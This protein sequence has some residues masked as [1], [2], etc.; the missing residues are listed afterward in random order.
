[1]TKCPDFSAGEKWE[2]ETEADPN[3]PDSCYGCQYLYRVPYECWNCT[4]PDNHYI[5][6][7]PHRQVTDK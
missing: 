6:E 2:R 5:E 4:A 3:Y 7:V 1:M